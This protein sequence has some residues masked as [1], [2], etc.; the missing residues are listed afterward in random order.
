MAAAAEHWQ[1]RGRRSRARCVD[2]PQPRRS[3]SWQRAGQQWS[4]ASGTTSSKS[5]NQREK[6]QRHCGPSNWKFGVVSKPSCEA[7]AR[8]RLGTSCTSRRG[9]E[10]RRRV[11]RTS[12]ASPV[13]SLGRCTPSS[14]LQSWSRRFAGSASNSVGRILRH[15]CQQVLPQRWYFQPLLRMTPPLLASRSLQ[16]KELWRQRP[17]SQQPEPI[18]LPLPAAARP[19]VRGAAG[20]RGAMQTRGQHPGRHRSVPSTLPTWLHAGD[21]G[22]APPQ[23]QVER[24]RSLLRSPQ[25]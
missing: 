2:L 6:P 24:H 5:C 9:I 17:R 10:A 18:L 21:H 25:L 22:P 15:Q 14:A 19:L 3:K 13:P 1:R 12:I 23:L 20:E 11:L 7:E 16:E 4:R 8:I